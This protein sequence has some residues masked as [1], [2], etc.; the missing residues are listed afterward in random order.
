MSNSTKNNYLTEFA[1][2]TLGNALLYIVQTD[3]Y[4]RQPCYSSRS[5]SHYFL[6]VDHV[7]DQLWGRC[8]FIQGEF[9][10]LVFNL[11]TVN[12][13][14]RYPAHAKWPFQFAPCV[15][16]HSGKKLE[17]QLTE[18]ELYTSLGQAI[19]AVGHIAR[20]YYLRELDLKTHIWAVRQ[21]GWALRCAELGVARIWAY[22]TYGIYKVH[23]EEPKIQA[24]LD[25]LLACN[26]NWPQYEKLLLHDVSNYKEAALRLNDIVQYYADCAASITAQKSPFNVTTDN[27]YVDKQFDFMKGFR[28]NMIAAFGKNLRAFY[29]SGSAARGDQNKHSDI[30]SIAIFNNIDSTVLKKLRDIQ[31]GDKNISVYT[32]SFAEFLVYP[33]FRYYTLALG[34]KKMSGDISLISQLTTSDLQQSIKNNIYTIMQI[35]R[36]YLISGSYGPRSLHLLKLMT[37]LADH[38]VLR[39][40]YQIHE[41]HYPNKKQT[42]KVYFQNIPEANAIMMTLLDINNIMDGL[43]TEVLSGQY[44][45]LTNLYKQLD[46]F[47]AQILAKAP[48]FNLTEDI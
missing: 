19:V 45:S 40:I 4:L 34:T 26:R 27:H 22:I 8:R 2:K 38:G 47:S 14:Q 17:I 41:G 23:H 30:D 32:L 37:K 20:L 1:K 16:S 25:W 11:I 35:S 6:I 18:G 33:A 9:P 28:Q 13:L 15:Y 44:E 7:D 24:Q 10:E 3:A 21:F 48:H 46:T 29:L 36:A 43:T 31:A 5:D 12:E 42:V 39:L